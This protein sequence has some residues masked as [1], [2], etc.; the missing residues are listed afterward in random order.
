MAK[1]LIYMFLFKSFLA[2]S[3]GFFIFY[4]KNIEVNLADFNID[5]SYIDSKN[6]IHLS[7]QAEEWV[8]ET[9]RE[10]IEDPHYKPIN[11][12][13]IFTTQSREIVI[14]VDKE[15]TNSHKETLEESL[16]EAAKQI[17]NKE[18]LIEVSILNTKKQIPTTYA[19]NA[20]ERGLHG[21]T[22][23]E[24]SGEETTILPQEAILETHT[25]P[26]D[27]LAELC[28]R[29]SLEE[30]CYENEDNKFYRFTTYNFVE[31]PTGKEPLT[32]ERYNTTNSNQLEESLELAANNLADSFI[33]NGKFQYL[34]Y[35]TENKY[36]ESYNIIRHILGTYTLIDL[37]KYYEDPIYLEKAEK[38]IEFLLEYTVENKEMSY[39]TY[40]GKTKLG[41]A[42]TA[43]LALL[44]YQEATGT[45][46]YDQN[47]EKLANFVLYMQKDDGGYKN[48]YPEEDLEETFSTVLYTGESNLALTRLFEKTGDEKYLR[49]IENSYEW[50]VEY[51]ERKHA[52]ALVSWNSMALAELYEL[53][54]DERY[55]NLAFEMTDWLIDTKQYTEESAPYPIYEGAFIINDIDGGLECSTAAYSEGIVA[56]YNLAASIEDQEHMEKYKESLSSAMKFMLNM[57]FTEENTFYM[58]YPENAIGGFRASP[59]NHKIRIDFTSHSIEAL[60]GIIENQIY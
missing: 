53:T 11:T 23:I 25:S 46:K 52:P 33:E 51:F 20:I 7:K 10:T 1:K 14:T 9:V 42:A 31:N 54:E 34:Y 38:S 15:S 17:K 41:S 59:Y 29:A 28:N 18:G 30:N 16:I 27:T 49:A 43:I 24:P 2:L 56:T 44:N 4:P 58:R 40:N 47:I 60:L 22:L 19:N 45:D 35:P 3:I 39:I 36:S 6:E 8:I 12:P 13:I 5:T 50:I 37:Y 26:Q 57:Q 55:A 48:F 21:I 32:L